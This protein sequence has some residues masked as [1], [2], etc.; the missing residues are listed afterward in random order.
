MCGL[1]DVEEKKIA[2]IVVY[3]HSLLYVAGNL[4]RSM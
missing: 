2:D 4:Q 3:T 1:I